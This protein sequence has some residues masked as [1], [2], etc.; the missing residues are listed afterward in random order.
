[1]IQ[2]GIQ[3]IYQTIS[4]L[5]A[6]L[7]VTYALTGLLVEADLE[8]ISD[9]DLRLWLFPFLLSVLCI[10]ER[11]SFSRLRQN[12]FTSTD[13]SIPESI[14]ALLTACYLYILLPPTFFIYTIIFILLLFFRLLCIAIRKGQK[15]KNRAV[16]K[17]ET[18]QNQEE[19]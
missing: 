1:M 5:F 4:N 2:K 19:A 12:T 10:I 13:W 14:I 3:I 7:T 8:G 17:S 11:I 6:F 9:T 15:L 16:E 18:S